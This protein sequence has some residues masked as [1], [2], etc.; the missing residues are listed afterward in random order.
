MIIPQSVL[1]YKSNR[2]LQDEI[3]TAELTIKQ[4]QETIRTA[5][6]NLR[7]KCTACSKFSKL[8]DANCTQH[9]FYVEPHGCSGGD[10]WSRDGVTFNCPKCSEIVKLKY[11]E[12]EEWE[13]LAFFFKSVTDEHKH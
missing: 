11:D 9:H 10:Y 4:L 2:T 1:K 7:F 13:R 6:T 12:R 5:K 3:K 8:A